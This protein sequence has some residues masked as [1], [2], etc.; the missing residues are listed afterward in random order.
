MPKYLT[1]RFT[2][3]QVLALDVP[4]V[5]F[6]ALLVAV[7]AHHGPGAGGLDL[8]TL[9]VVFGLLSFP[10]MFLVPLQIVGLLG[11]KFSQREEIIEWSRRGWVRTGLEPT[12]EMVAEAERRNQKMRSRQSRSR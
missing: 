8:V 4:P 5:I 7:N 10:A 3:N 11:H 12:E 6:L 1:E 9:C 2:L